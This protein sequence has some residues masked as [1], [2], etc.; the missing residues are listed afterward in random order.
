[1]KAQDFQVVLVDLKLPG[2]NGRNVLNNVRKLNPQARTLL[3]TGHRDE[4][5]QLVEEALKE[6][7]DGV[8][9]K[10]FDVPQLLELLRRLSHG[11]E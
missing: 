10:P 9:Y 8:C 3:I 11:D 6:G 2:G 7:A 4:L 5:A 1:L